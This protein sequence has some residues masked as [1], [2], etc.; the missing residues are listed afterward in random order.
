[1]KMFTLDMLVYNSFRIGVTGLSYAGKTVFLTSLI[2]HLKHLDPEKFKYP[3]GK[4]KG[5][6]NEIRQFEEI[7]CGDQQFPYKAHRDRMVNNNEWPAKTR[8]ISRYK[9]RFKRTDWLRP[10][11]LELFD[12]PGERISDFPIGQF[13]QYEAWSNHTLENFHIDSNRKDTQPYLDYLGKTEKDLV[14][15]KLMAKP[16]EERIAEFQRW[17]NHI[18]EEYKKTLARLVLN[19][20]PIVS[21]S[22]FLVDQKGCQARGKTPEEI[23]GG[24]FSGLSGEEFA[25]LPESLLSKIPYL[26]QV[27]QDRYSAYRNQVILPLIRDFKGCNGMIILIDIP[28]ILTCGAECYNDNQKIYE[29]LFD[30][31]LRKKNTFWEEIFG[32]SWIRKVAVLANKADMVH[33]EDRNKLEYLLSDMFQHIRKSVDGVSFK[34]GYCSPVKSTISQESKKMKGFL[35]YD[36]KGH[37]KGSPKKHYQAYVQCC[38]KSE[39]KT[40]ELSEFLEDRMDK[41]AVESLPAH[42][43]EYWGEGQ[44]IFPSVYPL[45]PARNDRA[46]DQLMMDEVLKFFTG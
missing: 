17:E 44:F 18:V 2:N 38:Q 19:F 36:E 31:V 40:Q 23:A 3:G 5:Q 16:Y 15:K 46:P 28:T 25:P 43:P 12:F 6:P 27:F 33:G 1:M 9:C 21:P 26:K 41:F 11:E 10:V 35:T 34:F 4:V 20:R 22:T 32:A 37:L 14:E 42:W 39:K 45:M 8:D 24:R 30:A 13:D 29:S 7:S